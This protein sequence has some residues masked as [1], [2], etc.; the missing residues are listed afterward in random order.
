MRRSW[1]IT[2]PCLMS[3]VDGL[4]KETRAVGTHYV[5]EEKNGAGLAERT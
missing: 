5:E 4:A 3:E 1:K 2:R